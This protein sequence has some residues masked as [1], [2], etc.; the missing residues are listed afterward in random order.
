MKSDFKSYI[1]NWPDNPRSDLTHLLSQPQAFP[2]LIDAL[3]EPFLGD[4]V[5]HVAT[6]DAGGFPLGGAIAYCL[7]AGA[8]LIRKKGRVDWD[9]ES[10]TGVDYTGTEK[11]L[12]ICKDA[13]TSKDRVLI[14][15]DWSD[16]G[17][18]LR[19][20][21]ELVERFGATV[22]GAACMHITPRV[23]QNDQLAQYRLHWVIE[24]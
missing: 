11:T 3:A 13:L 14:V 2:A 9:V 20:A 10:V 21:I 6:V 15:D 16:S 23:R 8:V 4:G 17:G 22:I 24:Y 12:E 7:N 1:R 5:T 19:L 18:Q